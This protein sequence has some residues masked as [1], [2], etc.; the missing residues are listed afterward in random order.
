[1]TRPDM[2]QPQPGSADP[3]WVDALLDWRWTWLVARTALS[4]AY[5]LGA[6]TKLLDFRSAVAEEERYGLHP[7]WLFAVLVVAT[8]IVGP[9]LIISNRLVW[10]GAGMLGV[11]TLFADLLANNFWTMTGQARFAAEN[12]FFEHIGL[13]GGFMLVALI[14]EHHG[15]NAASAAGRRLG[16][17]RQDA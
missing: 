6:A 3:R 12:A 11:F 5:I 2:T 10:L 1:M 14:A 8:E 7:G 4:G 9:A 13:I 15:R 16:Q 17:P